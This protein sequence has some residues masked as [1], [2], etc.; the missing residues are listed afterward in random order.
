[1]AWPPKKFCVSRRLRVK[2]TWWGVEPIGKIL[3]QAPLFQIPL[4]SQET[5]RARRASGPC[6]SAG[7]V[8]SRHKDDQT[9]K[10][11]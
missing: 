2:N 4:F 5:R 9:H 7:D 11:Q 10:N 1:M 8:L 6:A 3:D